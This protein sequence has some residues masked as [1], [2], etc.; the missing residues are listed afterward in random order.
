MT[1]NP[2]VVGVPTPNFNAIDREEEPSDLPQ[3]SYSLYL[4]PRARDIYAYLGWECFKIIKRNET[5]FNIIDREG[6][7]SLMNALIRLNAQTRNNMIRQ[8]ED[9]QKK[10]KERVDKNQREIKITAL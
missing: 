9:K 1:H 2:P 8:I 6:P 3:T 5:F 10:P 7:P 4:S